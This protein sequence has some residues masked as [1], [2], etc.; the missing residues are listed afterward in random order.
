MAPGF[1][2]LFLASAAQKGL[3]AALRHQYRRS[4]VKVIDCKVA[5]IAL[6]EV[7]GLVEDDLKCRSMVLG[8]S[9]L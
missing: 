7:S 1:G 3:S 6:R 5:V 4:Q 9:K 2:V 8:N